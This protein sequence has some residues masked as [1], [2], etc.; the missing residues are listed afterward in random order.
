MFDLPEIED[1]PKYDN[2]GEEEVMKRILS[3]TKK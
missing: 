1:A 2:Y 3:L